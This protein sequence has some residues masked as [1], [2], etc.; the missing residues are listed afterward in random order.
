MTTA[1]ARPRSATW[2]MN[3][4]PSIPGISRSQMITSGGSDAASSSSAALPS[5]ASLSVPTPSPRR[6]LSAVRRWKAWSS[7]TSTA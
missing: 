1:L 7:T 6:S 4:T 2:R 3:S 5:A